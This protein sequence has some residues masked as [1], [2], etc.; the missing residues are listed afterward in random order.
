MTKGPEVKNLQEKYLLSIVFKVK[1]RPVRRF[2]AVHFCIVLYGKN[3]NDAFWAHGIF[4]YST[5]S[6]HWERKIIAPPYCQFGI[7]F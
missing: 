3:R 5:A 6:G 1:G 4:C 7:Q 2:K